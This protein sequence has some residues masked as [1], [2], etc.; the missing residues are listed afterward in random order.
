M[1]V[2]TLATLWLGCGL[3]EVLSLYSG[4]LTQDEAGPKQPDPYCPKRLWGA[5]VPTQLLRIGASVTGSR[6]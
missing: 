6:E 4:A 2:Q 1:Q 5:R 3:C